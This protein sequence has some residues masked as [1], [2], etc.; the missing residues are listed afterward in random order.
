M[1]ILDVLGIKVD[2]IE[3]GELLASALLLIRVIDDD[4]KEYVA[5]YSSD[6]MSIIEKVGMLR[7]AERVTIAQFDDFPED[8][9]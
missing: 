1:S 9:D 3:P 6:G 7:V 8:D 4:G 5:H 2:N